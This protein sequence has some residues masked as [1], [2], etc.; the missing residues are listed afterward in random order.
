MKA[1]E[2]DTWVRVAAFV[3]LALLAGLAATVSLWL[4]GAVVVGA[5]AALA[6]HLGG[7]R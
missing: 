1:P 5:S 4:F 2:T 3:Y 7:N 6:E